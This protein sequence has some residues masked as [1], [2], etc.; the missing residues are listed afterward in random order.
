MLHLYHFLES[1]VLCEG[2]E[3][4]L[5]RLFEINIFGASFVLALSFSLLG[6]RGKKN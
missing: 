6:K 4:C 1:K 2:Q 3:H 5:E